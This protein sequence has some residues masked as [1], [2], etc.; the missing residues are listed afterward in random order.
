MEDRNPVSFQ[1]FSFHKVLDFRFKKV[2]SF[3]SEACNLAASLF[4][5]VIKCP[6]EKTILHPSSQW[7]C[8]CD[9]CPIRGA[10]LL[11]Q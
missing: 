10:M 7:C 9:G 11:L 8:T 2:F 3:H 1:D 5:C 4:R 6:E